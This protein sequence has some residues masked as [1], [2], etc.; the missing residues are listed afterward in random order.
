MSEE[1]K[2]KKKDPRSK[3]LKE[4]IAK[5]EF[6]GMTDWHKELEANPEKKKA[7]WDYVHRRRDEALEKKRLQKQENIKAAKKMIPRLIAERELERSEKGDYLPSPETIAQVRELVNNG[8]DLN[9]IRKHVGKM[10][11]KNWDKF[12][13]AIFRNHYNQIEELGIDLI[14]TKKKALNEIDKSL[15]EVQREIREEKR[16]I[17]ELKEHDKEKGNVPKVRSVNSRLL[18]MKH[19]LQDRKFT[20][21]TE[22]ADILNRVGAVG[23]RASA[24]TINLNF[25]TP[26]PPVLQE[27]AID[28]TPKDDDGDS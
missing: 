26:R 1:D 23:E 10:T 9:E 24:A 14:S 2:I 15:K 7:Y 12:V 16:I 8:M 18:D 6:G 13:K 11:Q 28:V 22:L 21:E 3:M 25:S 19:K 4:R 27:G 20:I 17:K 5:G